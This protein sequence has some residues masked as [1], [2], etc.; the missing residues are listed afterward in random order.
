M[1][2]VWLGSEVHDW[3]ARGARRY[4][5]SKRTL[6]DGRARS[7][8]DGFGLTHAT[9]GARD[10]PTMIETQLAVECVVC[11]P[12]PAWHPVSIIA[13]NP[14]RVESREL[15][16]CEFVA[17]RVDIRSGASRSVDTGQRHDAGPHVHRYTIAPDERRAR[18][19]AVKLPNPA[20]LATLRPRRR[21]RARA[22]AH[23]SDKLTIPSTL[24]PSPERLSVTSVLFGRANV[25]T[26]CEPFASGADQ[27]GS[28][29]PGK[30]R[31]P[32]GVPVLR[33]Y[34]LA[35][36]SETP[37]TALGGS[38]TGSGQMPLDGPGSANSDKPWPAASARGHPVQPRQSEPCRQGVREG[39]PEG[40]AYRCCRL[41]SALL[42]ART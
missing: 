30:L 20:N 21:A 12:K 31:P 14:A 39:C 7:F 24:P 26:S 34:M 17:E 38:A 6:G 16:P 40:G 18:W 23:H 37:K 15:S 28:L 27:P 10:P 13:Y 22:S 2:R 29:L 9:T 41:G 4:L 19:R 3:S 11:R 33:S 8:P 42:L 1:A 5:W 35:C 32:V 36:P 25:I